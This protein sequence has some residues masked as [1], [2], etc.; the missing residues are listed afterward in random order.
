MPPS[1]QDYRSGLART[2]IGPATLR[3]Q[4]ASGVAEA[5]CEFLAHLD[6]GRIRS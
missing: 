1:I 5:A 3:N 6:L 2:A 4:G